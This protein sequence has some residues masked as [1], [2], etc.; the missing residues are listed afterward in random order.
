[1]SAEQAV[2]LAL[3]VCGLP[4][5]VLLLALSDGPFIPER[6]R[7]SAA[8]ELAALRVFQA[9]DR[10]LLA[11]IAAGLFVLRICDRCR[12]QVVSWLLAA[13]RRIEP[14]GAGR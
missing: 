5:S 6:V 12:D 13:A 8:Y 7:R 2:C 10:A 9:R 3:M 11:L 14:K 4:A 1:M